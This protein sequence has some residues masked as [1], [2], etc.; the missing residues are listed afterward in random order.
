M[1]NCR[2]CPHWDREFEACK[3]SH[4]EMEGECLQKVIIWLLADLRDILDDT[5]EGEEWKV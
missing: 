5:D 2:E 3:R 1:S 4:T